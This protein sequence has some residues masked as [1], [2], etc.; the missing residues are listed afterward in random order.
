MKKS[1]QHRVL[2]ELRDNPGLSLKDLALTMGISV[3]SL[4]NITYKLKS[5]GYVEKA[6]KGYILTQ[7]G[8]K[9]LEYLNKKTSVGY[10]VSIPNKIRAS[11]E[12][13]TTSVDESTLR[14]EI[15]SEQNAVNQHEK[16]TVEP[17]LGESTM[18][19]LGDL[20][21]R[22]SELEKRINKLEAHFKNLE[23]ALKSQQKK[24][25]QL[26]I[27]PPVMTYNEALSK[28]G[29]YVEKMI[30]ENKVVKIGSLLVDLNFYINFKSK[31]PLKVIDIDKLDQ[32]E[33]LLLEEM[34]R[35]ALVVLHAGKEYRL[36][37]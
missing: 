5:M 19:L 35:E 4:K 37:E 18:M 28:Y 24:P 29:S 32:Y 13:I 10:Q 1:L 31:F 36:I 21:S 12:G 26:S 2:E 11:Q 33:R 15:G 6:G 25:E 9:F 22:L 14:K 34:R 27:Y 8:E 17:C 20:L 16:L 3:N 23:K 7:Q 30:N